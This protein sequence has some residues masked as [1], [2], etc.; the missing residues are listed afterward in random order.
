M[1]VL[2]SITFALFPLIAASVAW[3]QSRT[4][5]PEFAHA[6]I[7]VQVRYASGASGQYG[8]M[9]QLEQDGGG[10]VGQTQTDD[11][12]KAVF[13]PTSGGYYVVMV[14]QAGYETVSERVDLNNNPTAFVTI[15]LK[16]VKGASGIPPEGP[17]GEISA[18]PEAAMKEFVEGE[19]LIKKN[20]DTDGGIRHLRKA[21]E[22]YKP[23]TQAYML[24][25]LAYLGQRNW[26]EAQKT[27]EQAAQVRPDS[28]GSHLGL[29]A[30]LNGQKNFVAAEKELQRGVELDPDAVEGQ[31]E[32]AKTYWGLGRWEEAERHAQKAVAL[33]PNMGAPHVL[34]GNIA[35]R[36]QDTAGAVKEF[37]EYL[38]LD[39]NGPMAGG[40]TQ[41]V[42]K[43]EASQKK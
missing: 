41:M 25:G 12:G 5:N 30:A 1:K 42:Q 19:K 18:V 31:Y 43:I 29:G 28:V 7:R 16:P 38:R 17:G 39:P 35:L 22:L 20:K 36:K 8:V 9:V 3:A 27:F 10:V 14:K 11:T 26:K 40:V 32:L 23:F 24:I 33:A 6:Q 21:I 37:Q 2:R 4:P 34:L 15:T 13:H